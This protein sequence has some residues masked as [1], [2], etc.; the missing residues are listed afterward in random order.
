M[1]ISCRN[2]SIC[3][4]AYLQKPR[5]T[6]SV[7]G[8]LSRDEPQLRSPFQRQRLHERIKWLILHHLRAHGR[9]QM[10]GAECI[11]QLE[12]FEAGG[13]KSTTTRQWLHHQSVSARFHSTR[14]PEA[15]RR[16][17]R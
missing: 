2:I 16:A 14:S 7:P 4:T 9:P 12:L 1:P 17:Q 3:E 11:T 15:A 5:G 10:A 13:S 8:G 6:T